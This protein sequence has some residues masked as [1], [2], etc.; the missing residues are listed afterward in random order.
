VSAPV[1]KTQEHLVEA[2]VS[3]LFRRRPALCGFTVW[4]SEKLLVSE[5]TVN[6]TGRQGPAELAV[7]IIAT[8]GDLID[9]WPETC[10]LLHGR[11]FARTFH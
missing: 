11:T 9:E 6:A 10:Q 2:R 5:V 3:A 8:L 1:V 4:H 7:E